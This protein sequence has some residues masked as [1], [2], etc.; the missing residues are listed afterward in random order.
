MKNEFGMCVWFKKKLTPLNKINIFYSK[1]IFLLPL[2][3]YGW[4][5][6]DNTAFDVWTGAP[7]KVQDIY[8]IATETLVFAV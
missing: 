8:T 1:N 2:G 3:L 6:G 4:D 5:W 7:Y